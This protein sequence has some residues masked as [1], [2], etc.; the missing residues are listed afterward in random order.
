MNAPKFS[1][2]LIVKNEERTLPK[3]FGS[4]KEYQDRG[5][6][7][8]I[9]DT[10]ST[11]KT[12]EI[13]K[14]FGAK[15]TEVGEKFIRVI[16]EE[17]AKNI[18]SH[19][20]VDN[21]APIVNAGNRLFNFAA[22]RNYVTALASNDV[23]CTLDADEAYTT[24]NIDKIN[25]MIES[26]IEQF[27]Y[28]F[29]YAHDPWGRPAVEFVQSKMFDR[30]KVSWSGIVHEVLGGNARRQ[31]VGK[32]VIYLEH[33]QEPGK[34]H[35]GNYLVGLAI[36]CFE[37]PDKDRQSHYFARE[38]VW[39]G[40]P[41]SA[42]KEFSRHITMG[43]WPAERAQSMIFMG[44]CYG[45][46]GNEKM[47]K[48]MYHEA[49]DLD[50]NRRESLIKLAE[51]YQRKGNHRAV[52]TFATAAI[53]IPWTDYYANSK[54]H[55]EQY[56]HELLYNAKGWLG[57]I[58]GAQHHILKCLDYQ[59]ENPKYMTDT[60]YYFEYPANFIAGWMSFREQTFLFDMAKKMNSVVEL[61]SWKGKSTHA[62][63]SSKCPSVTAIDTWKGS[64]F[65]PE[66]HAEA[67]SGSV[68]ATFKKNLEGFNNL[69]IIEADINEA[70]KQFADKSVDAIFID[71]GH[72]E[73][74]VR[75]DIE[76]WLPKARKVICGHDYCSGW[77]GVQQAVDSIF[78]KPDAVFDTIWVKYL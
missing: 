27:E 9:L 16:T 28:S 2:V 39:T 15:V 5:G 55:Y 14:S 59:R 24:F 19:F 69:H 66:A 42:L 1:I 49:Y 18:N 26:G 37:N 31:L 75:N 29:V 38:M 33:Y 56:P 72:T 50:P 40:R 67:A 63:C 77:P 51:Y 13:A 21:E 25:Q 4:L 47:Q 74:E 36:D 44:D 7:V 62:L 12:V 6:E 61:G 60:K 17:E 73:A 64:A 45:M 53:D 78:G 8:C 68:F 58:P 35:R 46:L 11:D 30:R 70:V 76:K 20:V 34:E 22:A 43:G 10:G 57:D 32:D 54:S 52:S 48:Q 23:V 41:K 3:L 65:E 71:A